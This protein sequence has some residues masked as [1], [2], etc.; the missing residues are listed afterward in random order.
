MRR[1]LIALTVLCASMAHAGDAVLT[2][3]PAH[4]VNGQDPEPTFYVSPLR[5][6]SFPRSDDG[7]IVGERYVLHVTGE[8]LEVAFVDLKESRGSISFSSPDLGW[9]GG[10][11]HPWPLLRYGSHAWQDEPVHGADWPYWSVARVMAGPSGDAWAFAAFSERVPELLESPQMTSAILHYDGTHWSVDE[12]L[13]QGH[14]DWHLTDACQAVDGQWWFVGI[15]GST[16]SGRSM[17]LARLERDRLQPVVLQHAATERSG[18]YKIRC[19][20]DGTVWAAGDRRSAK[21][22]PL[23]LA[24]LRFATAWESVPV[25]T[26]FPRDPFVTALAPV[27]R[28]EVWVSA[29]CGAAEPDCCE[30]FLH[31]RDGTWETVSLPLMPGG[32]CTK[33]SIADMQFVSPDEGWAVGSDMEPGLG[34]GRIFHYTNG[35]WRLRNW[36]WH[37]WNAPWFDLFS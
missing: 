7:W 24:L 6:L 5:A 18:L 3:H 8:R 1:A 19:L 25:P 21:D 31:Y 26:V 27:S 15:D 30:R 28:G 12:Q 2:F 37:F 32:R 22:E 17:L 29:S 9:A 36:N 35:A 4:W 13:L 23:Q 20:P 33:V 16:A 11:Q 14:P 10:G 34:G